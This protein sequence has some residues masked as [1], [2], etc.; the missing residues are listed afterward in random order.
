MTGHNVVASGDSQAA[1]TT[2]DAAIVPR[3]LLRS[4]LR[5]LVHPRR[6]V[7]IV[8]LAA[9]LT[10]AQDRFS[11]GPEAVWLGGL[12]CLV[13]ALVAPVSWR[14]LFPPTLDAPPTFAAPFG[15]LIV[16]GITGP[17]R[18]CW[19]AGRCPSGWELAPRS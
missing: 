6:L 19:W 9:V 14:A 2:V 18:C 3:S 5:A 1:T 8:L 16:Y 7:P 17:A 10:I 12:M 13:F 4:T 15:R 11:R